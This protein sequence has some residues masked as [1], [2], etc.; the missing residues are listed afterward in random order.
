MKLKN[1]IGFTLLEMLVVLSIIGLISA[2][3]F[4]KLGKMYE[5]VEAATQRD[6]LS[7]QL[8]LLSFKAYQSGQAFSLKQASEKAELFEMPLGWHL[9][10]GDQVS[11]SAVGVCSGGQV[12]FQSSNATVTYRLDAPLCEPVVL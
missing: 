6:D 12:T 11:Y 1:S 4:P 5:R 8:K 2:I 3:S 7:N 10:S 9:V